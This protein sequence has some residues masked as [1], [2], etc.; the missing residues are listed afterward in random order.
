MTDKPISGVIDFTVSIL[1]SPLKVFLLG[2]S[3]IVSFMIPFNMTCT[4]EDP[5]LPNDTLNPLEGMQI[6]WQC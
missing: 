6:F 5:D 3:R 2:G 1:Q 4:A